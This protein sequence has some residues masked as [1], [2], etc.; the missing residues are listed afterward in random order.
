MFDANSFG[1]TQYD[2]NAQ[3]Q[4]ILDNVMTS[5]WDKNDEDEIDVFNVLGETGEL[6][7]G[8]QS[9]VPNP[10]ATDWW[11]DNAEITYNIKQ[12]FAKA[13]GVG[14]DIVNAVM[15][16][17]GN[18]GY[19]ILLNPDH[20]KHQEAKDLFLNLARGASQGLLHDLP[21]G[22]IDFGVDA[23][24]LGAN[25]L[26]Y[27]NVVDPKDAQIIGGGYSEEQ[28]KEFEPS[29]AY[30]LTKFGTQ[31]GGGYFSLA[32]LLGTANSANKFTRY[33]KEAIAFTL[34]GGTLDVT[35]GNISDM[36]N[37]TEYKNAVTELMASK[38]GDDASAYDRFVARLKN[39]GEEGLIGMS[40]PAL[41]GLAK[42]TKS[43]LT[44]P[45]AMSRFMQ[46]TPGLVDEPTLN[47]IGKSKDMRDINSQYTAGYKRVN[48]MD[49]IKDVTTETSDNNLIKVPEV[50]IVDLEGKPFI[51]GMADR[52]EAG[53]VLTHVND[54]ELNEGVPL[55]GGQNY[56]RNA[57]N[58]LQGN[59]WASAPGA[60]TTVLNRANALKEA[61]GQDPLFMPYAMKPTGVD[62]THQTTELM[63]NMA[64]SVLS[65][66]QK[67]ALNKSIKEV[68]PS[69]KGLG[70][71][72]LA[73]ILNNTTGNQRKAIQ[74]ILDRDF[75]EI[76]ISLP[77]A[78][79]AI[80][81]VN[82]LDVPNTS[83]M[84][85]GQLDMNRTNISNHPSYAQA[86]KGDPVGKI[87]E[88]ISAYDL[89]TPDSLGRV[90]D[91]S[92][93]TA[94]DYRSL[95][96]S[97]KGGVVDE[98]ILRSLEDKGLL[99]NI[100]TP[101]TK[102]NAVPTVN[103]K[104][105]DGVLGQKPIEGW[106]GTK[107][108]YVDYGFGKNNTDPGWHFGSKRESAVERLKAIDIEE[109]I[110]PNTKQRWRELAVNP[111]DSPKGH[112]IIKNDL[113]L[114]NPL[115]VHEIE[116]PE[117]GTWS[118]KGITTNVLQRGELPKG[119]TQAD[120][121]A[122]KDGTLSSKITKD[123][124]QVDIQLKD[125]DN[126]DLVEETEWIDN[127]L[128]DR[129]YDSIVYDNAYE[130]YGD[131]YGV[132]D[133]DKIK[134]TGSE[135]YAKFA[136]PTGGVIGGEEE[137]QSEEELLPPLATKPEKPMTSVLS[138]IKTSKTVLSVTNNNPGNIKATNI[139][140]DGMIGKNG[141]FVEFDNPENGIRALTRDLTNKRKRGLDTITKIINAYAPPT[142]N[143]TKSYIK[144]VAKDMGLSATDK[145]SDK[146]MYKM[147]KAMTKHEGGK[148]ALKHF[149]DAIIKK[150]MKSA[151]KN[152]YQKFK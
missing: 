126:L 54:I 117:Y 78:R 13:M 40:I 2:K 141:D 152:K 33:L 34:P 150:G 96:M 93:P 80:S 57:E 50:S 118:A 74:Q 84:N 26:G 66:A 115:R 18:S 64:D 105:D 113:D 124:K 69:W 111:V 82:Q 68:L 67:S 112:K 138:N 87:K 16:I 70:S 75:R 86:L 143:D 102:K 17:L 8:T 42:G 37:T 104:V 139:K 140:W 81:D 22:V 73:E 79:V 28:Q 9:Y 38:V 30:N 135:R 51:T 11:N 59:I 61:T 83:L 92:N 46:K 127:F 3:R 56:M 122:Y 119:F 29:V 94:H 21:Q 114:E 65:R 47:I 99:R 5:E 125:V 23:V 145:L 88:Q 108:E 110:N 106:H 89:L 39:M 98:K 97:A 90:V 129:G 10:R 43:A 36:I 91:S 52:S 31:L 107:E 27:D 55:R 48:E 123:G 45:Q 142:E 146:N 132:Y 60:N 109:Q 133:L 25:K 32:K 62:F 1:Q 144:D 19:G 101:K 14:E 35:E 20:P 85:I 77:E 72:K 6:S 95:T 4:G 100:D 53:R 76:G 49:K 137:T 63:I 116:D 149:T 103:S 131:A 128:E 7:K 41:Y 24:N 15:P 120:K 147:I 121:I 130:G 71:P 134:Q 148:E 151:Y 12:N 58:Y 44:D 136:I